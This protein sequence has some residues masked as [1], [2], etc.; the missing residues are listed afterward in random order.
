MYIKSVGK[1]AAA[2]KLIKLIR[3]YLSKQIAEISYNEEFRV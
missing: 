3:A 1:F 2:G